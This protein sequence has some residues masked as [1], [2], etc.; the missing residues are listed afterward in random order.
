MEAV[1]INYGV[2]FKFVFVILCFQEFS[3]NRHYSDVAQVLALKANTA[4]DEAA[5][6][7]LRP[8]SYPVY[9]SI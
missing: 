7:P 2:H 4:L 5:R 6:L 1:Y 8:S 3:N 9:T